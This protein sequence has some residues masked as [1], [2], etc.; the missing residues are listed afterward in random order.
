[1]VGI[2]IDIFEQ[3]SNLSKIHFKMHQIADFFQFSGEHAPVTL[4][5]ITLK[6]TKL[7]HSPLNMISINISSL[8]ITLL[9]PA[10]F[11]ILFHLNNILYLYSALFVK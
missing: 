4:T 9:S 6:C 7:N 11:G 8:N 2:E 5:K 1:M 10:V 3:I